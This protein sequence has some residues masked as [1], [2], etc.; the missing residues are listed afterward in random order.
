MIILEARRRSAKTKD[1]RI[2][3]VCAFLSLKKDKKAPDDSEVRR[4]QAEQKSRQ[5]EL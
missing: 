5:K 1:R 3:H 2:C 4:Q